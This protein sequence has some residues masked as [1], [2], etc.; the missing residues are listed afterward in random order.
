MLKKELSINETYQPATIEEKLYSLWEEK[1]FFKPALDSKKQPYCI[2]IPPPN[3]TGTLHMGHALNATLQD[4]LIRWKR[5]LGY[6][7]LWIPGTDHAG[8][9]TQNVVERQLLSEGVD[10]YTIG[11][12]AFLERVWQWKENCGGRIIDQLKRIGASCDWS[13]LRFTMDEGLSKAVREVFLRLFD[14]G[15][16]YRDLRLINW[17]PRCHTALSDLEVEHEE[18]EGKLY[19][20]KYPFKDDPS[21]F[22]TVATTRPETMLGDTAVAV[23]PEDKRYKNLVGNTIILPL[24]NREIP[25]IADSAVDMEF[26]TGA[27]KVTPAHDF[28]DAE[29]AQRHN[30]SY[31]CVID[32][33][34]KMTDEAGQYKALDRY[35]ARKKI[36]DDLTEAGLLDKVEKHKHSVGHCYRCK[37]VIEPFQTVQW[38]VKIKPLAEQALMVVEEGRIRFIPDG[39]VNNYYAWMRDI[40]DWCISRQL[41]WGHRI[42]VWYCAKCKTADGR[43][44]GDL[45][46]IRFYKPFIVN[47]KEIWSGTYN[48]LRKLGITKH[49]IE[50]RAKM[51][52]I[53]KE[54]KPFAGRDEVKHCPECGSEE[55]IQDPDVLDTWFSSALWPFSTLGWP[56]EA[57][58]LKRF[59][60]TNVLV[61]GFDIIFFW[62]ARMIM[63]G[64]KFMKEV[65]F[66]DVYIHALIRDSKGQKMSKSKGNVIDPI[67]MIEKYGADAF[68]FTL[69]AFAAQG[70]DIKFSEERVEG[71]R[72][73]INKIWNAMKFIMSFQHLRTEESIT[74]DDMKSFKDKWILSRLSET[75]DETNKALEAYRFNDA[76][77]TVYQFLWHEFCDWY[78]EL[79]KVVL[80][81]ESD[82]AKDTINCLF[83]VFETV[84]KLLHPFMPFVTEEI[85]FNILGKTESIMI[86]SYPGSD[87]IKKDEESLKKMRYIMD[88][89][90]GIRSIRGELNIAP[91]ITLDVYI[92]SL[93]SEAE[94]ILHEGNQFILKLARA[95]NLTIGKDIVRQKGSAI[96]VKKDFEI[97]IPVKGLIDIEQEKKR[98]LKE[99]QKMDQEI[100]FLNK[101]LMNEDFIKNAPQDVVNKDKEKYEELLIKS[102]KIKE[103]VSVLEELIN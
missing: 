13:R 25:I 94:G 84:L 51:L 99:L 15:L 43:E 20:I 59:Y 7:A 102:D 1:G 89:V 87:S 78:I 3:V 65:P 6:D 77:N 67:V 22:I 96:S 49:E 2:V 101:K 81:S 42:P 64:L 73:F 40:K 39:W 53:P 82:E 98:L 95:K 58:D 79:S 80:Y 76:A 33:E 8:I 26:G 16:I 50:Q 34:G 54:I 66:R 56:D 57:E 36:I 5:M 18:L 28:N 38:Y 12:D 103:N 100:S 97:Y 72:H 44:H 30:L 90:T 32:E 52:R 48:E 62:V 63:M 35:E 83:Y 14:E 21:Q 17:C 69:A 9:A 37:T 24:I 75:I 86:S 55:L 71:Y 91:S 74:V 10:R 23:N 27:V 11:R 68:R 29:M 88:A 92:K 85:W 46:E 31:V 70:R 19:Y 61:T 4:I 41:W 60:P 93:S 45:I 47:G